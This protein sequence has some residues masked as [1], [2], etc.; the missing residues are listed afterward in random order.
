EKPRDPYFVQLSSGKPMWFAGLWDKWENDEHK[1]YSC[2]IITTAANDKMK[3]IHH[4]MPVILD[5][6]NA[7]AWLDR[8]HTDKEYLRTLL[9]AYDEDQLSMTRVSR[10]VGNVRNQGKELIKF[11]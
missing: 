9:G 7:N 8:N 3:H 2:T 1:I 4:R 5:D 10:A 6:N 11:V